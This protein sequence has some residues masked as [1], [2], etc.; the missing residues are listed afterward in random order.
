MTARQA[1]WGRSLMKPVVYSRDD[2]TVGWDSEYDAATFEIGG[3]PNT[4]VYNREGG[5][6]PAA[7][8]IYVRCIRGTKRMPVPH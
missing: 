3:F 7:R 6:M 5:G 2:K 8:D 4:L 1:G